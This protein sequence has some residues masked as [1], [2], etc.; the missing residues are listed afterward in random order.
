MKLKDRVAFVTGF[1]SGLGRA[2]AV[3]FAQE[4]AAIIGTSA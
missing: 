2:I 3:L 1:G 4:G